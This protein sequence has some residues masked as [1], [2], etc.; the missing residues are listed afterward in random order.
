MAGIRDLVVIGGVRVVDHPGL[1]LESGG[2]L[3]GG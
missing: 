1:D 3:F 2:V